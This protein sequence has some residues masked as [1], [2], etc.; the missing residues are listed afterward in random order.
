MAK[1][2]KATLALGTV[3]QC[4]LVHISRDLV[5]C[6]VNPGY[7]QSFK[8]LWYLLSHTAAKSK[9]QFCKKSPQKMGVTWNLLI[10]VAYYNIVIV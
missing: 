4:V 9:L 8:V 5:M 2:V 7:A 10:T 6:K 3:P 1:N